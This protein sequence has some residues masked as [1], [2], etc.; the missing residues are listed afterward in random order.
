M[1]RERSPGRV[2]D[3]G[4]TA[5]T[6][7]GTSGPG[8][9]S[10]GYASMGTDSEKSSPN[11][12][13]KNTAE[14]S[15]SRR[16]KQTHTAKSLFFDHLQATVTYCSVFWSFGMCV[17]LL[18]PT[19]LD[20]G[21]Q[22]GSSV[23]SMSFAFLSQSLSTLIGSMIGGLLSD[24]FS[25]DPLL[26]VSTIMIAVTIAMI[27]LSKHLYV[28]IIDMAIM[29]IFMGIIDTVANVSLLKIYGKLVS[30]F[31]QALHFCY[32]FGAFISPIVAEP[33]LLNEDCS[34]FIDNTTTTNDPVVPIQARSLDAT[35]LP[36]VSIATLEEA[37]DNTRVRFA[38]W[39][40]AAIQIPIIMMVFLLLMRRKCLDPLLGRDPSMANL[41]RSMYEDLDR[42]ADEVG[43]KA[44]EGGTTR[45]SL[46][47][48]STHSKVI[49]VTFLSS[50]LLFLY[51]GL[52]AA[53]GGFI[54]A[55][56]MKNQAIELSA[57]DS[58]YITSVYWGS[59]AL[60][61][62]VS[63][64]VST[65]LSPGAMLM[66]NLLGCFG[67]LTLLLCMRDNYVVVYIA[68]SIFGLSLSSVYP[69]VI[70][71][72]EQYIH[73]SGFVTSCVVIGAATGEMAF[74]VLVGRVFFPIQP[75]IFLIFCEIVSVIGIIVLIVLFL[76]G[77]FP[78]TLPAVEKAQNA[79]MWCRAC[80]ITSKSQGLMADHSMFFTS[81]ADTQKAYTV[82]GSP[83]QI[84]LD[85]V[86]VST[87]TVAEESKKET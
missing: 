21:C 86:P 74:P 35:E 39:I 4:P 27:P 42:E 30:P 25:P 63:I 72:A 69:T 19:L 15:P 24:R 3:E 68:S 83:E 53:Y 78:K 75:Y 55:Y 84:P 65:K 62:L 33:F 47:C 9:P 6:G 54:F 8:R 16:Q 20:L 77:Y 64:P 79:Y 18:G 51:D 46:C 11:G 5:S 17:A 82:V 71:L 40:M 36:S 49:S 52:Q 70:A 28:L 1:L 2:D 59:F 76:F 7:L 61:R 44:K 80:C 37:Q 85:N 13:G 41:D 58:A 22:T 29:G 50:L 23:A 43:T 12:D 10:T 14:S 66:C 45:A 56:A 31:L 38:F 81:L 87:A 60:G 67:A 73:M 48:A 26:F 57:T 32:G 34:P